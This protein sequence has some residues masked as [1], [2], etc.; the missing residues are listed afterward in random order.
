MVPA[1]LLELVAEAAQRRA[2]DPLYTFLA[3]GETETASMSYAELDRR[4]RAIAGHLQGRGVA[5]QPVLLVYPPGLDYIAAFFGCVY[6]GALAVP[7]YPPLNERQASRVESV[8]ADCGARFVLSTTSV[9]AWTRRLRLAEGLDWVTTPEVPA[10]AA[11]EWRDPRVAPGDVAF[12]QYT[13]GSTAAPK[14]VALT[15][16]NLLHNLGLITREF[17]LREGSATVSWLPPYHDL[18]L[19]GQVLTPL[20]R[21]MRAYLMPPE[22]FLIRP[23]RWLAAISRSGAELAGGP[24]FAYDLCA[25]KVSAAERDTL[26]LSNW[27]VAY[28]AAEPVRAETLERFASAFAPCGFQRRAFYPC[29]G[30]AEATLVVSC[31]DPRGL[32]VVRSFE[33]QALEAGRAVSAAGG[34]SSRS[35]VGCGRSAPDQRIVIVDPATRRPCAP[36]EV[37]EIW[38][39]GPSVAG[40]YWGQPEATE[41]T[42]HAR[43]ADRDEGPFLRTGDLGFLID[44]ELFVTGRL[45]DLIIIRGRNHHPEDIE[46]TVGQSHPDLRPGC[47]TAFGVEHQGEERLVVIQE[48]RAGRESLA[49]EFVFD[50]IRDAVAR[51]HG[52]VLHGI[53]LVPPGTVPKTSSGKVRRRASKEFFLQGRLD[54]VA[55]WPA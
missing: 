48:A 23:I 34:E 22:A 32:P 10:S 35:L 42:F 44:G 53:V 7:A 25:R 13:S 43:L 14:G 17:D 12:I 6:A 55:S 21:G 38:V 24:N 2:A 9:A 15:H 40:R 46:V 8:A 33:K 3:D 37:G 31:S 26:D 47:G 50:A 45:K 1:N 27:R 28:D 29:Y 49:T 5:G 41:E 39:S 16:A 54:S 30:M 11:D 19:I 4:A 51:D 18:G 36:A 52:L 20:H